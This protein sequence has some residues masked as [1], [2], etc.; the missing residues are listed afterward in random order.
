ME[1]ALIVQKFWLDKIFDEGKIWEMRIEAGSGLIVG[2]VDIV[3]SSQHPLPKLPHYINYHKIEDLS[4]LDKWGY[5]W[6]LNKAK[7]F[8]QPIPYT[9]PKGAV[10]WVKLNKQ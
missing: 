10:I 5:A 3:D 2:C 4:L 8:E 7:R 6:E 1:R 9:H